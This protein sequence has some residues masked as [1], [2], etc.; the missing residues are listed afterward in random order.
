M[1]PKTSLS[2]R[3]PQFEAI[4]TPPLLRLGIGK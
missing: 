1:T 2:S 4:L 3:T